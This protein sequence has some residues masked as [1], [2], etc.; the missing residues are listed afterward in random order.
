MMSSQPASKDPDVLS[1]CNEARIITLRNQI[2]TALPLLND[3]NLLRTAI[4]FWIKRE[5]LFEFLS[6][7]DY[8]VVFSDGSQ[9]DQALLTWARSV[10]GHRLKTCIWLKNTIWIGLLAHC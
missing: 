9:V 8:S 5:V 4:K 6:Q 10:W 1:W 3:S 2:G 7:E